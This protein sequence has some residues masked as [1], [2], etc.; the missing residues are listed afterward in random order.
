MSL[1]KVGVFV[2]ALCF[3]YMLWMGYAADS[4]RQRTQ[5]F[6]VAALL[7]GSLL[8]FL[9]KLYR[10]PTSPKEETDSKAIPRLDALTRKYGIYVGSP[11]IAAQL[12]GSSLTVRLDIFTCSVIEVRYVRVSVSAPNSEEFTFESAE[13]KRIGPFVPETKEFLQKL[14]PAQAERLRKSDSVQI[15][16]KVKF[17]GNIEKDFSFGSAL[18]RPY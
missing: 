8:V 6:I 11:G 5:D 12:I 3:A 13:P 10:R 9:W 17:E 18:S 7:L 14:D 4:T 15:N 2:Q 16:G 1:E